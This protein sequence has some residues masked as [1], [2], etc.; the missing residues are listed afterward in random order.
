MSLEVSKYQKLKSIP[1]PEGSLAWHLHRSLSEWVPISVPTCECE[2]LWKFKLRA[3]VQAK[4][5]L[6]FEAEMVRQ[7]TKVRSPENF[8]MRL[9]LKSSSI[10]IMVFLP[11]YLHA[12]TLMNIKY[13]I[14]MWNW[15]FQLLDYYFYLLY[16]L[17]KNLPNNV[18]SHFYVTYF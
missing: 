4:I 12:F 10:F 17:L 15:S 13:L 3:K 5:T 1:W 6:V 18:F 11:H 9:I 2:H 7:F 8:M 14:G 16:Y